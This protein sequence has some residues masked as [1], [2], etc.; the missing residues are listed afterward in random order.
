MKCNTRLRSIDLAS[1][2]LDTCCIVVLSRGLQHNVALQNL[3]RFDIFNRSSQACAQL[4]LADLSHNTINIDGAKALALALAHH[5]S[6]KRLMLRGCRLSD[7]GTQHLVSSLRSN[8]S[9]VHIDLSL[10]QISD[11]SAKALAASLDFNYR[12][13][14]G[15]RTSFITL[16]PN[17]ASISQSI[18]LNGNDIGPSGA[19]AL[20]QKLGPVSSLRC[21]DISGNAIGDKGLKEFA[22]CLVAQSSLTSLDLFDCGIGSQGL[23]AF[24][25]S[26]SRNNRF[27]SVDLRQNPALA[28]NAADAF[29]ALRTTLRTN[30]KLL[31][32]KFDEWMVPTALVESIGSALQRNIAEGPR[33][34]LLMAFHK[35][36]GR[37]SVVSS[38]SQSNYDTTSAL[39]GIFDFLPKQTQPLLDEDHDDNFNIRAGP[40]QID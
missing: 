7:A 3:G 20:A 37:E 10:N 25:T 32:V 39:S 4:S 6:L 38:L 12:L 2:S 5:S 18:C 8:D 13:N 22:D 35:R 31:V 28:V 23:K 1:N 15:C 11:A 27:E 14:V 34:A 40:S 29:E 30:R 16:T 9:L 36:V 26:I 24:A 19:R 33:L 17:V 21:L